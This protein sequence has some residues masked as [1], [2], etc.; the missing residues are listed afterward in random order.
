MWTGVWACVSDHMRDGSYAEKG[1]GMDRLLWKTAVR[2]GGVRAIN[3]VESIMIMI[4]ANI[5]I[6]RS[7]CQK[8]TYVTAV[9]QDYG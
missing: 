3:G 8:G 2:Q 4:Q 6:D 7:G 1:D 9:H 5:D